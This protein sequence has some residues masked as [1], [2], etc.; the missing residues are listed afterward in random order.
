MYHAS[1]SKLEYPSNRVHGSLSTC[2]D[3]DLIQRQNFLCRSIIVDTLLLL[4]SLLL[5]LQF[6]YIFKYIQWIQRMTH[7]R[8][9]TIILSYF[10]LSPQFRWLM[11]REVEKKYFY[12]ME[13]L[14]EEKW[15]FHRTFA[16]LPMHE[17]INWWKR[18]THAESV[19]KSEKVRKE[20]ITWKRLDQW[21]DAHSKYKTHLPAH[22][23]SWM[24]N[25]YLNPKLSQGS[26]HICK[27]RNSLTD[28]FFFILLSFPSSHHKWIGL[29]VGALLLF[30]R[31]N[32]PPSLSLHQHKHNHPHMYMQCID[33]RRF[34]A[35]T[36][37]W[38]GYVRNCCASLYRHYE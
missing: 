23:F 29:K 36:P 38:S 9:I 24:T 12:N 5:L 4:V 11:L 7:V 13:K 26:C 28:F 31:H 33:M 34:C 37:Q 17:A 15:V 21:N 22:N 27:L 1:E 19:R 14:K 8:F 18:Y 10:A 20:R 25:Y 16:H 35:S 30:N 2:Y 32:F 3:I 6:L